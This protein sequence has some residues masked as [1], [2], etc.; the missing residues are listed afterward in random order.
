MS[1]EK[2][3]LPTDGSVFTNPAVDKAIVLAE[4]SG[5]TVTAPYGVGQSV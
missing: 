5:G 3:L 4:V 2:I 1:F